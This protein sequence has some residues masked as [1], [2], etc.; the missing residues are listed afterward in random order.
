MKA[1]VLQRMDELIDG[2]DTANDPRWVFLSCY[3][4]MTANMVTAVGRKDFHDPDW[5]DRLLHQFAD[6]YF[7]ALKTYELGDP[8]TPAVWTAAFEET[9]KTDA[10]ALQKLL[11]GVN[12]H[13]NYDLVLTLVDLLQE[14]WPHLDS[15]AKARRLED[16]EH[17]ND[18]IAA[19]IDE[20]QDDILEREAPS[21]DLIDKGLGRLDEYLI[22]RL[23]T[24]WR[25]RVWK[26]AALIMDHGGLEPDLHGQIE[27]LAVNRARA[28]AR[29]RWYLHPLD[30]I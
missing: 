7:R 18:I 14:E 22:A 30:L 23:I 10:M 3:R 26:H 28:I 4:A 24:R 5:V 9:A 12:A 2:W 13:I 15:H 11:L 8:G 20:V 29:P 17:V 21:L 1:D 19:T 6:Y 16:H 25:D 27:E